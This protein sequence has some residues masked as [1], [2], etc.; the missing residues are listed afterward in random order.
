[1]LP[2]KDDLELMIKEG[3]SNKQIALK[4]NTSYQR[5]T[6]LI[7][8]YEINTAEFR[9]NGKYITYIHWRKGIPV[10]VGLGRHD[11]ISKISGRANSHKELMSSGKLSYEI[12]DV[13]NTLDKARQKEYELIKEFKEKGYELFNTDYGIKGTRHKKYEYIKLDSR[14]HGKEI[15]VH[16]NGLLH[17]EYSHIILFAEEL[18]QEKPERLL[19]G[20]SKIINHSWRPKKGILAGYE[21]KYK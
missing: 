2:T 16:R 10:Y 8:D 4:Y 12:S 21:V 17:G 15:V 6:R 13:F 5:I 1:M 3:F 7:L 18:N 9:K 20:I 14:S 11:R 19:S